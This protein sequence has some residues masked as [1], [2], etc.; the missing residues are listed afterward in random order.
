[1]NTEKKVPR[2]A[3]NEFKLLLYR[4]FNLRLG[5]VNLESPKDVKKRIELEEETAKLIKQKMRE[6]FGAAQELNTYG[7]GQDF[8]K[9]FNETQL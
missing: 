7:D 5:P 3:P 1:M 8:D 2:K 9:W 6:S 4:F